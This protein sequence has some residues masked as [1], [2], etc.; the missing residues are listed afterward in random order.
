MRRIT[1]TGRVVEAM[2]PVEV[3]NADGNTAR[4]T[5]AISYDPR[6]PLAVTVTFRD[7]AGPIPWTFGRDLLMEGLYEPVGDGDVHIWPCLSGLGEAVVMIE[8]ASP[9]SAALV[10]AS[11]RQLTRF[12]MD[13]LASVPRGR[14]F[15]QY[16]VDAALTGMLA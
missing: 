6:D 5:A 3:S 13:T 15:E 16:N 12:V 14:E 9:E 4:M 10:Q 8:L 2:L 7:S 11:S 1:P